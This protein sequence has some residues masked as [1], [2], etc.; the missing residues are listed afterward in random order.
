MDYELEMREA[1]LLAMRGDVP[2]AIEKYQRCRHE[3][4]D[5]F[6]PALQLLDLFTSEQRFDEA[7]VVASEIVRRWPR[8]PDAAHALSR[9]RE[10]QGRP[11]EALA[12]LRGS[13]AR[14][15]PD[16]NAYP[17]YLRL[18]LANSRYDEAVIEADLGLERPVLWRPMALLAKIIALVQQGRGGETLP[19]FE[20]LD[21]D[22]FADLVDDWA[23]HLKRA[24]VLGRIQ[25]N[26]ERTAAAAPAHARLAS[27]RR[28]FSS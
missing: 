3:W 21:V 26:L 22:D 2:S 25:E 9:L 24:G 11:V 4:P 19:L 12:L 18:L 14:L 7:D 16:S 28:R 6:E 10:L 15:F 1:A 27:L 20:E 17:D 23:A 8:D 5:R 13:G